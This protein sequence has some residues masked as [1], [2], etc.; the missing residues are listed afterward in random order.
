[1]TEIKNCTFTGEQRGFNIRDYGAIGDGVHNDGPALQRAY[2]AAELAGGTV[3]FPPGTY[4]TRGPTRIDG[5]W[6]IRLWMLILRAWRWKI[7][8]NLYPR[9]PRG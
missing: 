9:K 1:M 4:N 6:W 3:Y 5:S 2:D 7:V 8:I